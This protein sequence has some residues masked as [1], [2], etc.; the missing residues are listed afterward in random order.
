MGNEQ[1][2]QLREISVWLCLVLRCYLEL[3]DW[4]EVIMCLGNILFWWMPSTGKKPV[5]FAFLLFVVSVSTL[6]MNS[7]MANCQNKLFQVCNECFYHMLLLKITGLKC[8]WY[9][10][11]FL[12][13]QSTDCFKVRM[14]V[15]T[16]LALL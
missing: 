5:L 10:I 2:C 8:V 9:T 3:A 12:F 7:T 16:S 6:S 14:S 15:N 11:H 1:C 13:H 4:E